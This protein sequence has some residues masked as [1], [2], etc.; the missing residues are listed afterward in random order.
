MPNEENRSDYLID[1]VE[2]G[3]FVDKDIA[4]HRL[5]NVTFEFLKGFL[6]G[7]E[8]FLKPNQKILYNEVVKPV[9]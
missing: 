4:T 7:A 5:N 6:T 3:Q 2:T 1:L 9:K 8:A